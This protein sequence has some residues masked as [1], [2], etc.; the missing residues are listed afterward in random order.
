M[1]NFLSQFAATCGAGGLFG[2]PP[3]YKYLVQFGKMDGE[4]K[5]VDGFV[6]KDAWL[7][8]LAVIE[9][10]VYLAGIIAIV[11]IIWGGFRMIISQ[12]NP[13]SIKEAR[14]T[15]LY[16]IIGLIVAISAKVIMNVVVG[17]FA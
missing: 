17:I 11:M 10:I 7:I 8:G 15:I 14:Q 9:M 6:L 1:F 12:G 2:I 5:I 3:W 16:A 13:E 4:C